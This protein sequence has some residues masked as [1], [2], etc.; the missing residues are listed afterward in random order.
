MIL[1][2][3][4]PFELLRGALERAGVRYA[5]GGSWASAAYG[6][7]RFT[8]DIDILVDFQASSLERFLTLL[9]SVFY[10]ELEEVA[11]RGAGLCPPPSG[12]TGNALSSAKR[13]LQNI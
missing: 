1:D 12:I 9:P 13:E 8:N 4:E 7:A 11:T 2:S 10:F 3:S 6:E 5:V